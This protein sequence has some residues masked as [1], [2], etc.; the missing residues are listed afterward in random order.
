MIRLGC[1]K[2]G[3]AFAVAMFSLAGAQG[4]WAQGVDS[5]FVP[6][7]GFEDDQSALPE[8]DQPSP[9]S[10]TAMAIED[11]DGF[12]QGVSGPDIPAS[13]SA[14]AAPSERRSVQ[15]IEK[16]I[17]G[18]AFNAALTGLFPMRPDELRKTL[19]VFDNS[20]QA[21]EIPVYP[22]PKPEIVVQ[23]VSLDPGVPPPV[24]N[25]GM[26][27]VTTLMF[28]DVT[29]QPWPIRDM[30][31]AG[32]FEI[33][34]GGEGSPML[35]I[36]PLSDFAYG[37]ISVRLLELDTPVLFTLKAARE[38][39]HYRFDARIAQYGP[40]ASAPLIEG[41]LNLSAGDATLS[42]VLDGVPPRGAALLKVAGVD[43]RT[44]AY[45]IGGLTYVRTPLT[46]LSPGWSNSV[47]S[48]DGMNVYA[49][50]SA[51]VVLLSDEGR[52]VRAQ[53]SEKEVSDE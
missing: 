8:S 38:K 32:N 37:N 33:I 15:D 5:P 7:A 20:K 31:W 21:T 12:G 39:I 4:V 14:P 36:M 23:T 35:R 11:E 17:R 18:Q 10:D 53:I 50:S 48:S 9:S 28:L 16:E 46:L 6:P 29:G 24:V 22:Y 3:L 45:S 30:T 13:P 27:H 19:E 25:V 52:V 34:D 44:T 47:S 49:L 26:G 1:N 43:G 41:G 40:N 42:S 51:P 2:I